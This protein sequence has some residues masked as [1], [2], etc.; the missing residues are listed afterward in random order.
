MRTKGIKSIFGLV[1]INFTFAAFAQPG[2][3]PQHLTVSQDHRQYFTFKG[4]P[5]LLLGGSDND[6]LFQSANIEQQLDALKTAGGNYVRCTMSSRDEGDEWPFQFIEETGKYDLNRWNEAYWERFRN[7]LQL[8]GEREIIVQIEVWATFDFYRGNWL[9]NPFN[10][11]NNKNYTVERTKLPTEVPTHPTRTNNSFFRS[12]PSS[13]QTNYV[14]LGHQQKFV[15]KIL[16]YTLQY[17]HVL[18][19]IDNETSVSSEWGKFWAGYIKTRAKEEANRPVLVTEM[20]DPWDLDHVAHRESFDH[21]EI[22]DFVEISQNNHKKGQEHWDNGSRQIQRL[23]KRGFLRPVTNVKIYGA[24]SG[25][26]GG[27][28]NDAIEKFIRNILFGAA[29]A[30]FH[31][32]TSG[33]GASEKAR[34]V[35]RS[36][37]MA[38][39]SIDFFQASPINRQLKNRDENEAYAIANSADEVLIYFPAKGQVSLQALQRKYEIR[40][41]DVS[42]ALWQKARVIKGQDLKLENPFEGHGMAIIKPI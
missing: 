30:R 1:L 7:F 9:K 34:A 31:R 32:P 15:D 40:W 8:T 33:I 10:P 39:D 20:W 2:S 25:R 37:R 12:I 29:S 27:N 24:D 14:V 35:I 3:A 17:G 4:E 23:K 28:D 19:C 11:D 42:K 16:S 26:H 36:V 13:P 41:L 18:Y 22:Y 5:L 6:N 21:P 38:T